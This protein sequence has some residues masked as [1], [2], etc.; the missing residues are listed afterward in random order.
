M[1]SFSD[2]VKNDIPV[3]IQPKKQVTVT[4]VR[5]EGLWFTFLFKGKEYEATTDYL[6]I[7]DYTVQ[8]SEDVQCGIKC[9]L[10]IKGL[11]NE[12]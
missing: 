3:T 11:F 2:N 10:I 4:A 7:T 1:L 9:F 5:N 12:H 6:E 8:F